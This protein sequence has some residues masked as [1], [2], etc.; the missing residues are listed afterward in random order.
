MKIIECEKKIAV[1]GTEKLKAIRDSIDTLRSWETFH[2]EMKETGVF[3]IRQLVA[4]EICKRE[5][6]GQG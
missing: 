4:I 3:T 6:E 2:D 1:Q 5:A